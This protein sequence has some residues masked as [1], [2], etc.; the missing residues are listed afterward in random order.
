M[1]T[2]ANRWREDQLLDR[3]GSFYGNKYKV[4]NRK[5]MY[6][7]SADTVWYVCTDISGM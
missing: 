1:G 7:G 3:F 5:L 2:K 6:L 4:C